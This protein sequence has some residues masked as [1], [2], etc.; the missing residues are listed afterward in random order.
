M[1]RE[2]LIAIADRFIQWIQ[3]DD[4]SPAALSACVA[5]EVVLH[6]PFPG[7]SP[8]F[9]GLLAHHGR[10]NTATKD[11]RCVVKTVAVDENA[12]IVTQFWEAWG[13]QTGYP[14]HTFTP[15]NIVTNLGFVV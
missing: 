3:S 13:H 4:L 5:P 7:L 9:A 2:N 10:V 12:S 15:W 14:P 8:D 6:V 11:M 1:T